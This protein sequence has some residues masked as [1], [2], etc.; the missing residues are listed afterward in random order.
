[1]MDEAIIKSIAVLKA[2][3]QVGLGFENKKK[4]R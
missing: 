3:N 1:M 2:A 4:K